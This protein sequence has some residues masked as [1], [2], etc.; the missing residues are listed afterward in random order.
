MAIDF[1]CA[2]RVSSEAAKLLPPGSV[3]AVDLNCGC[4]QAQGGAFCLKEVPENA[5]END[6]VIDLPIKDGDCM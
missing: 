5:L 4:P 6:P 1:R 3:D 2:V